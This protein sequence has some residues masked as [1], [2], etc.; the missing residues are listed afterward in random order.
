MH[1]NQWVLKIAVLKYYSVSKRGTTAKSNPKQATDPISLH[2]K[3]GDNSSNTFPLNERKPC[4]TPDIGRR[5]PDIGHR[6]AKKAKIIYPPPRG[7]DIIT[8][9]EYC[10][11]NI[12]N[13]KAYSKTVNKTYLIPEEHCEVVLCLGTCSRESHTQPTWLSV[14]GLSLWRVFFFLG[15]YRMK[16]RMSNKY[17]YTDC[18]SVLSILKISKKFQICQY[19]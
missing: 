3:F 4:V 12:T 7:V 8:V 1:G 2:T 14:G 13:C 16:F 9:I 6:T 5:T 19:F 10:S 15:V 18:Y 11:T 17:F